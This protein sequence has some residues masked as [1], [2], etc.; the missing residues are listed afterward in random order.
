MKLNVIF[1]L[2]ILAAL[3]LGIGLSFTPYSGLGPSSDFLADISRLCALLFWGYSEAISYKT[4]GPHLSRRP[5]RW[6]TY[7]VLAILPL[8]AFVAVVSDPITAIIVDT[9]ELP[10]LAAIGA[11]FGGSL[12]LRRAIAKGSGLSVLGR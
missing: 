12:A 1:P 4:T 6:L 11:L 3:V 10:G 8:L 7:L 9:V 5:Q 2:L